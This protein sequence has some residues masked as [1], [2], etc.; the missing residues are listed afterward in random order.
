MPRAHAAAAFLVLA[1]LCAAQDKPDSLEG[2]W[3]WRAKPGDA[4]QYLKI[5]R[6]ATGVEVKGWYKKGA[7]EVGSYVGNDAKLVDGVLTY[8]HH[9][10]KKPGP[11]QDNTPVRVKLDGGRLSYS[12]GAD[13]AKGPR[14]YVRDGGTAAVAAAP[15]TPA[16]AA[17]AAPK[18]PDNPLVGTFKGTV[19]G[20]QYEQI[21]TLKR[22]GEAWVVK[23]V[24][25]HNG[26]EVGAFVGTD[27]KYDAGVLSFKKKFTRRPKTGVWPDDVPY[28]MKA[29]SGAV[30][31]TY[32]YEGTAKTRALERYDEAAGAAAKGGAGGKDPAAV[33]PGLWEGEVNGY[34]TA[35]DIRLVGGKWSVDVVYYS[36]G[37]KGALTPVAAH[38]AGDPMVKDGKLVYD[39]KFSK[40]P[41]NFGPAGRVYITPLTETTA[42]YIVEYEGGR[43]G[44]GSKLVRVKK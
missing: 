6:T 2:T 11:G 18:Q 3:V 15:A 13:Y 16:P 38:S 1:G 37:A 25:R 24:Y 40:K 41:A 10:I 31:Y 7:E 30:T 21:W 44:N 20:S 39:A 43:K 26:V 42:E 35:W 17:P 5:T 8:T 23:G 19:D 22:E 36:K 28:T 33:L 4:D 12:W 34:K 14:T 9:Y 27:V 32:T 29:D